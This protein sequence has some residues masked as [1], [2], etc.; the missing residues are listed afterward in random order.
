[1]RVPDINLNPATVAPAPVPVTPEPVAAPVPVTP[2]PSIGQDLLHLSA[3]AAALEAQ[4]ARDPAHLRVLVQGLLQVLTG[5]QPLPPDLAVVESALRAPPQDGETLTL[6]IHARLVTPEGARQVMRAELSLQP[7]LIRYAPQ[8]AA[9]LSESIVGAA[10][11]IPIIQLTELPAPQLL[12]FQLALNPAALWP[13]SVT[14]ASGMLRLRPVETDEREEQDERPPAA[15]R[16]VGEQ[17]RDWL[18]LH[19]ERMARR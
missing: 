17:V 14:I 9:A 19:R 10:G 13:L 1:M 16:S 2:P 5:N 18:D 8:L 15:Q 12:G 6:Q 11:T 3:D 7:G 4:G